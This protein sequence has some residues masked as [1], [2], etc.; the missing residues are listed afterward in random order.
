MDF[1]K[2]DVRDCI[3]VLI[4]VLKNNRQYIISPHIC[5]VLPT[6][7]HSRRVKP[8]S[9]SDNAATALAVLRTPFKTHTHTHTRRSRMFNKTDLNLN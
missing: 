1:L 8:E 5:L 4:N 6:A 7:S 3:W 9:T 2:S